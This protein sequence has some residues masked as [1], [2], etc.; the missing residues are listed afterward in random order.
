MVQA[1]RRLDEI[2]PRACRSHV[3]THHSA[4]RMANDYEHTYAQVLT[5]FREQRAISEP[6]SSS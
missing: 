6:S 4:S 2:D 1:L 3:V 5:L